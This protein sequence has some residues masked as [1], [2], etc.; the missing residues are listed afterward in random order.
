[1]GRR[2]AARRV[3][4]FVLFD[5]LYEDGSRTSNRKV[6]HSEL[7]EVDEDLHAETYIEAQDRRIAEISGKAAARLFILPNMCYNVDE[8]VPRQDVLFRAHSTCPK[9][10]EVDMRKLLPVLILLLVLGLAACG[11]ESAPEG[12]TAGGGDAAAGE[13]VYNQVA[14][15]ACSTCHSLEPGVMLVGPSLANIGAEAGSRLSGTSAEDY[16]RQSVTDPNAHI[17]EGFA[18][19]LMPASYGGQLTAQQIDDLVAYMLSLK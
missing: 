2:S 4:E 1:M 17:V 7:G 3:E 8:Q 6:P 14:A 12:G 10:E 5:V 19:N 18:A 13:Q 16:L 9:S 11:G 15:P